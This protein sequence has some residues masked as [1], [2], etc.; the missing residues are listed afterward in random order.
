MTDTQS[1]LTP[2]P[3][4]S[5]GDERHR[6]I[7]STAWALFFIWMGI[8]MLAGLSWAWFLVGAGILMLGAQALRRQRDLKVET[9]GVAVGVVLLAAGAW[10][11]LE[12]PLP[13]MPVILILLGAWLL[14]K[15]HAGSPEP[16]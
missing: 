3:V 5:G 12:L 4:S 13:F 1:S 6:Q 16:H 9:F 7:D 11:L 8:V 15:T 10:D 14:W 2:S